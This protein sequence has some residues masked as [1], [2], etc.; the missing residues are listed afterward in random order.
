MNDAMQMQA[1]QGSPWCVGGASKR[2]NH[3][4]HSDAHSQ[5]ESRGGGQ[6]N[7]GHRQ[8]HQARDGVLTSQCTFVGFHR[9]SGYRSIIAIIDALKCMY[10]KKLSKH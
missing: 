9:C 7:L 6:Q 5:A 4:Q 1:N 8:T 2:L 10:M 3:P